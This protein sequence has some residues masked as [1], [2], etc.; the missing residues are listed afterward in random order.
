MMNMQNIMKQAQ[1][2]QKKMQEAQARIEAAEFDGQSGG[3]MV[4]VLINGK[5][6]MLKINIDK[7]LAVADEVDMLEDLIMTAFNDAK[8]KVD[9]EI[10]KSMGGMSLGGMKLPFG[11]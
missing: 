7:S 1:V 11:F 3:G 10:G 2:M 6:D 8:K 4:K 9:L 5:F